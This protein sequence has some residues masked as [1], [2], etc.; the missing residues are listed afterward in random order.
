MSGAPFPARGPHAYCGEFPSS[1]PA[2]ADVKLQAAGFGDTS[3]RIVIDPRSLALDSK[4]KITRFNFDYE[5]TDSLS[6]GY[7]FGYVDHDA[8]GSGTAEG[9]HDRFVGPTREPVLPL[10]SISDF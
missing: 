2:L 3:G 1:P 10:T 6:L 5:M 8:H 7:Q 9:R 4:T